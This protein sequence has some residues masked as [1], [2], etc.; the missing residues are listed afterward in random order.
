M[1]VDSKGRNNFV[2]V[3]KKAEH[4]ISS[5]SFTQMSPVTPKKYGEKLLSKFTHNMSSSSRSRL[6]GVATGA[7][8]RGPLGDQ[9]L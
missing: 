5:I 4:S 9:K 8:S 6:S 2:K 1:R 7:T 3:K